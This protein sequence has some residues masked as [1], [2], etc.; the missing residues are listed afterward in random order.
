MGAY[1]VRLDY[2]TVIDRIECVAD[3]TV[4]YDGNII[5]CDAVGTALAAK[6]A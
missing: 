1:D 2:S 5:W 6:G 3:G 4:F